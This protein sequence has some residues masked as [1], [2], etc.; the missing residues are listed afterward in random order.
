MGLKG[1]LFQ[2]VLPK[3]EQEDYIYGMLAFP[4]L[5][6]GRMADA[7]KAARKGYEKNKQDC[8]AQHAV[9]YCF[10]VFFDELYISFLI[11]LQHKI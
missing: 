9:S 6:L 4:L 10:F 1:I 7:E 11:L 3:N 5:E 2:Q 8:W